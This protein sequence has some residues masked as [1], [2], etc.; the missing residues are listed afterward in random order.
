MGKRAIARRIK[1]QKFSVEPFSKGSRGRGAEPPPRPQARNPYTKK[2]RRVARIRPVD[3][4]GAGNPIKGSPDLP[5]D[6]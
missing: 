2:I 6:E 5:N 1:K 4:S 3:G